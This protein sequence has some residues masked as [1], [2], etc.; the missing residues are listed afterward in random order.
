MH[1]IGEFSMLSK[2]TI[3]AL[4]YYEEQGLIKPC[5]V[6]KYTNYRYY[7]TSQLEEVARIV[8]LREIGLSIKEIRE[9]ISGADFLKIL[10]NRKQSV[11][12]EIALCQD[13]L[14]KIN[15]ALEAQ[16]MEQ[17]IFIKNIPSYTVYCK[18]GV[19]NNFGEIASFVLAAGQECGAHNPTLKCCEPSYCFVEYLDGE[20]RESNIT[21]RYS[22]AVESVGV[23]SET[24]KFAQIA[25]VKCVCIQHKGAYDSLRTSYNTILK[26]IEQ[27]GLKMAALPRECYIDGCWNKENVEDYLTEIQIPVE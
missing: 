3:K 15:K 7:E 11:C 8:F 21:I 6:D 1:K 22:E 5:F 24:I 27:N 19:I 26:Y 2:T 9:I 16:Q 18:E 10:E 4:R 25:A 13:Q 17:K 23:E 14:Q 12:N 20:Y